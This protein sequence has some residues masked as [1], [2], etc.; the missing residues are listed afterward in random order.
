MKFILILLFIFVISEPNCDHGIKRGNFFCTCHSGYV[1]VSCDIDKGSNCTN[2]VNDKIRYEFVRN[3]NNY[4]LKIKQ[5]Y[6]RG[7][8]QT[9]IITGKNFNCNYPSGTKWTQSFDKCDDVF[10]IDMQQF[11]KYGCKLEKITYVESPALEPIDTSDIVNLPVQV[12]TV[13]SNFVTSPAEM[14]VVTI[15]LN[16]TLTT[17]IQYPAYLSSPS[18]GTIFESKTCKPTDDICEQDWNMQSLCGSSNPSSVSFFTKCRDFTTGCIEGQEVNAMILY[19]N[20]CLLS[21]FGFDIFTF[22]DPNYKLPKTIFG[23]G[24]TVYLKYVVEKGSFFPINLYISDQKVF[25]ESSIIGNNANLRVIS[26]GFSFVMGQEPSLQVSLEGEIIFDSMSMKRSSSIK[27]FLNST[28]LYSNYLMF[29]IIVIVLYLLFFILIIIIWMQRKKKEKTGI[30]VFFFYFAF[31]WL[32]AK[33]MTYS[34]KLAFLK[35][36]NDVLNIIQECFHTGSLNM[37]VILLCLLTEIWEKRLIDNKQ[38]RTYIT[39]SSFTLVGIHFMITIFDIIVIIF[40][41]NNYIYKVCSLC[42]NCFIIIALS[43]LCFILLI[44]LMRKSDFRTYLAK[45]LFIES[46]IGIAVLSK[47]AYTIVYVVQIFVVKDAEWVEVL[48]IIFESI[49]LIII[50]TIFF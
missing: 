44:K 46:L 21:K 30:I 47:I 22:S 25:S 32:F 20:K 50:S 26:S 6:S 34:L 8:K 29:F 36:R 5:A 16:M 17:K 37:F 28:D 41:N 2:S 40:F 4:N 19:D 12:T 14:Q 38:I 3:G 9:S 7:R 13:P 10:T 11:T 49:Y 43:S 1:G 24:E 18:I 33:I 45:L 27:L 31:V 48:N 39:Y 35:T 23:Y 42:L 15:L